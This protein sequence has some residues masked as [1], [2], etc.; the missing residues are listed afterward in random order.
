MSSVSTDKG[1]SKLL[2]KSNPEG[3][4][5]ETGQLHDVQY[6]NVPSKLDGSRMKQQQTRNWEN[7]KPGRDRAMTEST[8]KRVDAILGDSDEEE[9]N[10]G[11]N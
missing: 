1:K 8:K 9:F 5:H 10:R 3:Y 4:L 11:A 2:N 7:D 6:L